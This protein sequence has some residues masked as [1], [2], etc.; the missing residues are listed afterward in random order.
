MDGRCLAPLEKQM[1]QH[2]ACLV[3]RE[4]PSSAEAL[5][6]MVVLLLLLLLLCR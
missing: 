5:P 3:F 6:G 4:T 1:S 2:Q